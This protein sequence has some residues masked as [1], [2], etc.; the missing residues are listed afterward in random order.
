MP[1]PITVIAGPA[2]VVP[3]NNIDTDQIIPARFCATR[4]LAATA[5]SSFTICCMPATAACAI[6]RSPA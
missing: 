2:F 6:P 1:N 5:A 4:G 3:G